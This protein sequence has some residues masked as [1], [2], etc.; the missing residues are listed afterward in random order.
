MGDYSTVRLEL[1]AEHDGWF[2]KWLKETEAEYDYLNQSPRDPTGR[3][4]RPNTYVWEEVRSGTEDPSFQTIL[5]YLRR[6]GV[7]FR[8]IDE[9]CW[10]VW[11]EEE[12]V[13]DGVHMRTR[14]MMDGE[15]VLRAGDFMRIMKQRNLAEIGAMVV[16]YFSDDPALKI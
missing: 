3:Y 7:P 16:D 1:S 2:T 5:G 9:G 8:A 13:F 14:P 11:S 15:I 6:R 12:V 4:Q 10:G